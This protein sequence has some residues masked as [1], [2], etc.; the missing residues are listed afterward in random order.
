MAPVSAPIWATS[1]LLQ[2]AMRWSA[3]TSGHASET[4]GLGAEDHPSA[5]RIQF[6]GKHLYRHGAFTSIA[7][8]KP[9]QD[10]DDRDYV[11][12]ITGGTPTSNGVNKMPEVLTEYELLPQ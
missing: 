2:M 4:P 5:F 7:V 1:P 6:A 12:G 10:A 11:D 3:Q 8:V 9:G